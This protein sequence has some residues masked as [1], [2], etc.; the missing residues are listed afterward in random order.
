MKKVIVE[1]TYTNGEK[2]EVEFVTDRLKWSIA[3][4][5]RNRSIADHTIISE[6]KSNS[7]GMLLG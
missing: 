5:M 6:N 3:Q 4:W 2:E 1:F 7:K